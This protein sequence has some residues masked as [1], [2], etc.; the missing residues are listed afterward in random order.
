L[1]LAKAGAF[2]IG[3]ESIRARAFSR[4]ERKEDPQRALRRAK[5][6]KIFSLLFF[7]DFLCVLC[8]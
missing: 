7:A 5:D 8:G 2:F 6:K 4:K 3:R 1:A